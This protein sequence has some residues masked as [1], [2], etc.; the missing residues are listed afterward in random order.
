MFGEHIPSLSKKLEC[1]TVYIRQGLAECLVIMK[2]FIV[3]IVER[4]ILAKPLNHL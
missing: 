2:Q 1:I 4:E 3:L